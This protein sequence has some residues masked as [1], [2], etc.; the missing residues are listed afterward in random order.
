MKKITLVVMLSA[1][2]GIFQLAKA[3]T[4]DASKIAY[5]NSM[6]LLNSMPEKKAAD[7]QLKKLADQKKEGIKKQEEALAAKYNKIQEDLSKKSQTELDS[8]KD[9]L[10]KYEQE[11]QTDQQN[12]A[13]LREDAANALDKK[14]AE[15]YDPIMKKA[16][17]AVDAVAKEKG[18]LY[19][20]DTSQPSLIYAAG[21]NIL[22]SVKAKL[23]L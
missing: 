1:F 4:G 14:Q 19:V 11:L 7:E 10:Q 20:F 18:Y 3:Q 22:A 17:E 12:L 13:T 6:E 16:Q 15:L 9:Q 5:I 21:P 8:M 2:V 23:G